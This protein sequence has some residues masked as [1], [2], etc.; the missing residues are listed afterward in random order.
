MRLTPFLCCVLTS[1][2]SSAQVRPQPGGGDPRIQSVDYQAD[3]VVSI[4][5]TPGYLVTIELAPDEK[6]Q[7]AAVGD[8]G[9]WQVSANRAGNRLFVKS[10]Q[11][12]VATN[13][14]VVTDVRTYTFDLS[15]AS[16]NSPAYTIRFRYTSAAGQADVP[17]PPLPGKTGRY[18]LH[19]DRPLRPIGIHDD[20]KRTY[21]QWDPDAPLPATYA[22]DRLG[23]EILANG[24]MRGTLYVLDGVAERLVFRIDRRAAT[25]RRLAPNRE[26]RR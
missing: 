12:A 21:I 5:A 20:G 1:A 16:G 15:S 22:L 25:A 13:L 7:S 6:V 11:P 8:S 2:V 17:A 23:R 24:N 9:A 14:I 4:E 19:G 18:S 26:E 10:V 3:Q